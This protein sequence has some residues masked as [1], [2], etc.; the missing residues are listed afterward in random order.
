M[1]RLMCKGKIHR[2]TVT[3]ADLSYEGS[4]TI[5]E[6]LLDAA[7]IIPYE[8]VQVYNITNGNRFETYA[9]TGE[10]GSGAI[11]LNGAAAHMVD[12]GDLVIIAG[13]AMMS[14]SEARAIKPKMILV[15]ENNRPIHPVPPSIEKEEITINNMLLQ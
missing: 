11:C 3:E 9:I 2:A 8:N 6:D 5:D 13:Y 7:D 15:D 10:R 14:E 1:Q 4:I 12:V